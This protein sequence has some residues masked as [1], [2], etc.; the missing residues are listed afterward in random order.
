MSSQSKEE[1]VV[2]LKREDTQR[3]FSF[4]L[5]GAYNM[6]RQLGSDVHG[7]VA[8]SAGNHAQGVAL[9][10]QKLGMDA[11]IAMPT[12]TPKIKVDAVR[13]L[14]ATVK[15]VGDAYDECE[16]WARQLTAD[17]AR[18]F[19]PPF[20]DSRIIAGQGSVGMEILRQVKEAEH[21]KLSHVFVPVGGGGLLAGIAAYVKQLRPDVKVIGVE[22]FGA[23]AMAQSLAAGE[24]IT[25]DEV[26]KFADGVAVKTVGVE[27]FELC[28][29]LV[30][31]VVLVSNAEICAAVKDIFTATRTLVEPS[32]A[33]GL[34]GLK[35]YAS[36]YDVHGSTMVAVVSGANVNFERLRQISDLANLGV[37]GGIASDAPREMECVMVSEIEEKR[38]SFLRFVECL[39][40]VDI[41]ELRYR[42]RSDDE[43][44]GADP[45]AGVM[46]SI[47]V[48]GREELACVKD[49]LESGG[50]RTVDCSADELVT[51]HL[52]HLAGGLSPIDASAERLV[53]F[54][55]PERPGALRD[56]LSAI[57]PRFD[58]SL[59]HYRSE[60]TR[61]AFV[62]VAIRMSVR[63][64]AGDES[65]STSSSKHVSSADD[66]MRVL[67][68]II[69]GL[70]PAFRFR[71][72]AQSDVVDMMFGTTKKPRKNSSSLNIT[73][74]ENLTNQSQSVM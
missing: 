16:A 20:D 70:G 25:L 23:S 72:E 22:P 3:V 43:F 36:R 62:L 69:E 8:S 54:E 48:R 45:K 5:R 74:T 21:G 35:A 59:F 37:G 24:R 55:F 47:G 66:E 32:G 2:L 17:E 30:D 27:T 15:L 28:R 63:D 33:L 4:K 44:E 53:S 51:M 57:S 9:A 46:Y 73:T 68:T 38:G 29:A 7:V 61:A 12:T 39:G 58:I 19:V 10:A 11:V 67:S 65:L 14:G 18:V 40:D 41:T 1:N 34:A 71:E 42:R 56:F 26:D 64:D 50:M 31:G 49:T 52:K 6:M 13:A 60:G